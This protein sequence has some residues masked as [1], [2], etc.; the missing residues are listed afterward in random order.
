[1][2]RF[3]SLNCSLSIRSG[4]HKCFALISSRAFALSVCKSLSKFV[5]AQFASCLPSRHCSLLLE[6]SGLD[7]CLFVK[8]HFSFISSAK[9]VPLAQR[10]FYNIKRFLYCQQHFLNFFYLSTFVLKF[11]ILCTS[12]LNIIYKRRCFIHRLPYYFNSIVSIASPV[13]TTKRFDT[14]VGNT[15]NAPGPNSP[16]Y[17]S[18]PLTL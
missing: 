7:C 18:I 2:F 5:Q 11:F 8:V 6:F 12:F 16:L 4:T 1:M 17:L 10:L 14:L 3:L 15:A 13:T 9:K